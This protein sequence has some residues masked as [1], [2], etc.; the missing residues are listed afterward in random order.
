MAIQ[1]LKSG[2]GPGRVCGGLEPHGKG[3]WTACLALT[4]L[5]QTGASGAQNQDRWGC[6]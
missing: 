1:K 3:G 6:G 4:P 2:D 5:A